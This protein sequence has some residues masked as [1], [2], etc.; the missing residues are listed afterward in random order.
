MISLTWWNRFVCVVIVLIDHFPAPT[1]ERPGEL[2]RRLFPPWPLDL[3]WIWVSV[4]I[5]IKSV[6]KGF[7]SVK[8]FVL[9]RWRRA[10]ESAGLVHDGVMYTAG[11]KF[12]ALKH[13]YQLP[14]YG[15]RMRRTISP[16]QWQSWSAVFTLIR[17]HQFGI[18]VGSMN[19]RTHVSTIEGI[20]LS[21]WVRYW[22]Y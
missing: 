20:W 7:T 6:A 18:A 8:S 12:I 21:A 19:G 5:L 14:R 15:L 3:W 11:S 1:P 4:T 2:A 10:S 17:A 9:L 22:P 13:T 16:L